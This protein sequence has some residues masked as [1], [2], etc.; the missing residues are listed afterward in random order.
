[1]PTIEGIEYTPAEVRRL[2]RYEC[3][4]CDQRLDRACGAIGEKC[5]I[6]TRQL[7]R[8]ECLTAVKRITASDS[9][10]KENNHDQ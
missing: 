3:G 7:R 1:M 2:R 6:T 10:G 9:A 4:W 8:A 5:G